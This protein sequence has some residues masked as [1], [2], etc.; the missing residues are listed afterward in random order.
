MSL[1]WYCQFNNNRSVTL[2]G[3]KGRKVL[4]EIVKKAKF[5]AKSR[6]IPSEVIEK[7]KGKI[8]TL[9]KEIADIIK[10]EEEEKQVGKVV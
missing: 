1:R 7:Y 10:Q 5:P 2:V 3:E 9:E 6:V 8:E 4:K